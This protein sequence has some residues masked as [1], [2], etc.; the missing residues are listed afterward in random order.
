MDIC[1]YLCNGLPYPM[2]FDWI[3]AC[4]GGDRAVVRPRGEGQEPHRPYPADRLCVSSHT[5][6]DDRIGPHHLGTLIWV[7]KR[8]P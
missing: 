5:L 4:T 8:Y 6:P 2:T 7:A 1:M 3:P